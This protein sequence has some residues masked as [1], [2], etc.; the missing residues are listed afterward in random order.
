MIFRG[1]NNQIFFEIKNP[2]EMTTENHT[3]VLKVYAQWEKTGGNLQEMIERE[4]YGERVEEKPEEE[5][6]G[7]PYLNI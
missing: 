6:T 3:K 4:L 7:E 1:S 2:A 5:E